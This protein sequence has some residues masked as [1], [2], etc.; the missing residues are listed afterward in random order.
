[1]D[2]FIVDSSIFS[3]LF[4]IFI[5]VFAAAVVHS[6]DKNKIEEIKYWIPL[7][8]TITCAVLIN[9]ATTSNNRIGI[10]IFIAIGIT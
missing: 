5:H 7:N 2:C 8:S 6:G 4:P 3:I 10:N 1:M 9:I